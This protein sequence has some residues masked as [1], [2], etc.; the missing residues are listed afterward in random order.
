[1]LKNDH[2]WYLQNHELYPRL[3]AVIGWEGHV[4]RLPVEGFGPVEVQGVQFICHPQ[5][6]ATKT[7]WRGKPV[8]RS[9]HR[10][11]FMCPACAEWIPFG[12]AGQHRKGQKH[13]ANR[14][15]MPVG[16]TGY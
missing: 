4:S 9:A 15:K 1:M 16:Y 5:S 7:N 11:M 12:R 3:Q 13:Q 10:L 14:D 6:Q 8:H 2:G